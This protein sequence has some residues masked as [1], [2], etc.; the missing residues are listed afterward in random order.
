MDAEQWANV[1]AGM[2]VRDTV[3]DDWAEPFAAVMGE[4]PWSSDLD[5]PN[6]LAQVIHESGYLQRL[7]ENLSYSAE[8]LMAVWPRR[9]PTLAVA[10]RYARNPRALA[11][12][13]YGG[14]LGNR[15]PDDGWRYRGRGLIQI[16]GL[17]NY[18]LAES[19]TSMPLVDVPDMLL[20]PEP[21]LRAS[22]AWWES[23]V[24][25]SALGDV[26]RVTRYVNGGTTGL[27]ERARLTELAEHLLGAVL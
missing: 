21:A 2:G 16:T 4:Q 7:E 1:L 26:A 22:V 27:A 14:R 20:Q 15:N 12:Y 8:R 13:V 24:P 19:L 18:R 25:D 10:Q 11:C 5:L 3:A 23:S 6:F 17:D 9:F